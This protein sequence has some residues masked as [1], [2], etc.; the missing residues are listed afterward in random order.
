MRYVKSITIADFDGWLDAQIAGTEQPI[1]ADDA[2]LYVPLIRRAQKKRAGAVTGVPFEILDGENDVA[3]N[4]RFAELSGLIYKAELALCAYGKAYWAKTRNRGGYVWPEWYNPNSINLRR[5]EDGTLAG[6]ERAVGQHR[7]PLKTKDVL[8]F[9]QPDEDV[10][11]GPG[12]APLDAALYAASTLNNADRTL[13]S[14]FKRGAVR[15][16]IFAVPQGTND[17]EIK[18]LKDW[19]ERIGQAIRNAYNTVF[20]R[21]SKL[22][23]TV[24]G[25]PLSD[26]WNADLA[27]D[28]RQDIADAFDIPTALLL[29]NSANYA[30]AAEERAQWYQ[31]FVFPRVQWYA[32]TIN[33]QWL[34]AEGLK[35]VYHPERTEV[36]QSIQLAQVDKIIAALSIIDVN[37]A[38]ALL[39]FPEISTPATPEPDTAAEDDDP[40]MDNDDTT[41][42]ALQA[43]IEKW[44]RYARKRHE[45][46]HAEKALLF[47]STAIPATLQASIRGA[48]QAAHNTEAV[49]D[50]FKNAR[51]WAGYGFYPEG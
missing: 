15:T 33:A 31:D 17:D 18:K 2:K 20:Y 36:W 30:T 22:E 21:G 6:F 5:A 38:R 32:D 51:A 35:L 19:W 46:A 25:D 24:V 45:E 49:S 28:K 7:I 23:P 8:Y 9:W 4:P 39:G 41:R 3:E 48:L 50:I 1:S 34:N 10:E 16:T 14:Y 42:K 44:E 37:E 47:E 40:E 27:A 13:Y 43:D 26:I 11:V 12:Q 29:S